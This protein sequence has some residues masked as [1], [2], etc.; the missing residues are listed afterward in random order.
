MDDDLLIRQVARGDRAAFDTLY[1]CYAPHVLVYLQAQLGQLE[2][3]EEVCQ[4]VLLVVWQQAGQCRQVSQVSTWVFGIAS[5]LAQKARAHEVNRGAEVNCPVEDWPSR[6]DPA[7]ACE[8]QEQ[9]QTL[10]RALSLL[11]DDLQV[12]LRLRYDRGYTY[13]QIANEMGC[14]SETVKQRLQKGRRRLAAAWRQ[15]RYTAQAASR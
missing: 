10:S 2:V 7:M 8:Q 1:H 15:Q 14:S 4:D 11:P 13:H 12:T 9:M 5:H 3:A 6:D